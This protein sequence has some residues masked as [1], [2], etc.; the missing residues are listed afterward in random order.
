MRKELKP[1]KMEK[2]QVVIQRDALPEAQ[3]GESG[4]D[5]LTLCASTNPGLPLGSLAEC[6]SGGEI[7]ARWTLAPTVV[8]ATGGSSCGLC[9]R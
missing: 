6:A 3:W 9:V 1:L 8:L 7:I 2:A 5:R 4:A